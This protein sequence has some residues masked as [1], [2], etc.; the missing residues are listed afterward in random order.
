MTTKNGRTDSSGI[1]LAS[2]RA[3]GAGTTA[4]LVLL[5]LCTGLTVLIFHPGYITADAQYV[6]QEAKAGR[7]GD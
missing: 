6:Y 5:A 3:E 7:F 2:T 4:L 1:P